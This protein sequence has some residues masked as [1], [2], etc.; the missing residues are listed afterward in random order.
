MVNKDEAI[1]LRLSGKN[2]QEI[3]NMLGCSVDWCKVN[4]KGYKKPSTVLNTAKKTGELV[5]PYCGYKIT[6]N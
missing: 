4:L 6:I 3:S 5:C 1:K 2:Y